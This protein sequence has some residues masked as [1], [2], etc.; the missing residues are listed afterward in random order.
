MARLA[1]PGEKVS[2]EELQ[3]GTRNHGMPLE[4]LR[5]D[6]TPVGMHYLLVHFDVP[7]IDPGDW[8]LEVGGSVGKELELSLDD[9]RSLPRQTMPVTM[10][11]AGNG[12][13][14]LEPR[15]RSQPWLLEAVGTSEWT[16]TS[17]A[18]V[19]A[20][21]GVSPDAEELV[22][23]GADRG[24]EGGVEHDY[25][26][27]LPKDEAQREEVM[28]VYEMNGRPLEPQHGFPLRLLVPGWYG[29]ASVKWL[30][31]VE[32]VTAPFAGYQQAVAYRYQES[33]EDHG[34]PVTRIRVRALMIPPGIPDFFT[35]RRQLASGPTTLSGR[36]W[37]GGAPVTKVEVAAD[38]DWGEARLGPSVGPFAWRDWSFDWEASAGDHVLACRATDAEGNT[39]PLE[40]PWNL[41]G[42]GNNLVQEVAVTVRGSR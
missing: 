12:R 30:T 6:V 41:Q 29:M 39:Q 1:A 11:C 33:E 28:L 18:G 42:M 23:T 24:V 4:A 37:S 27:S 31:R 38:G 2:F 22:F 8:R 26:R 16:G 14:R 7:A 9:I 35:R 40:Q 10:E 15:P 34:V 3:L 25:Q 20:Q 36:A 21:A 17:L 32:A 5:Y 13:A 19:L